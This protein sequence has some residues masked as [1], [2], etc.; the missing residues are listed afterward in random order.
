MSS[1]PVGIRVVLD[2]AIDH[3]LLLAAILNFSSFGLTNY[4]PHET[5]EDSNIVSESQYIKSVS[6]KYPYIKKK[7]YDLDLQSQNSQFRDI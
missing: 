3:V 5:I 1:I 7:P 2:V 4:M 6:T